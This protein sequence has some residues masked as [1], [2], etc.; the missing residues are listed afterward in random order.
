MTPFQRQ[1]PLLHRLAMAGL[2]ALPGL[3]AQAQGH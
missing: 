2:L 3:N 1:R